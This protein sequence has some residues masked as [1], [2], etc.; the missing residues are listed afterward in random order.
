MVFVLRYGDHGLEF[1][2]LLA[3]AS[4]PLL[5]LVN[6]A[7]NAALKGEVGLPAKTKITATTAATRM[8]YSTVLCPLAFE[9][10]RFEEVI[11]FFLNMV[12]SLK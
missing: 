9:A 6:A 8:M 3:M 10:A 2:S 7:L 11:F 12:S 5:P 1:P 4:M